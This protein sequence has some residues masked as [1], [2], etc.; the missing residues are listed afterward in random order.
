LPP[1]DSLILYT[2]NEEAY[3]RDMEILM[4]T[5]ESSP[6]GSNF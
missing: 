3:Q 4:G 1:K 2:E 5:P 6:T